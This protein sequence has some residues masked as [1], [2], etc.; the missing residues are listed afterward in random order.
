MLIDKNGII[1]IN[2][3]NSN[4]QNK[5][6]LIING[7]VIINSNSSLIIG[8][9]SINNDLLNI[10]GRIIIGTSN[11]DSSN[12]SLYINKGNVLITSNLNVNSNVVITSNLNVNGLIIGNGSNITNLKISELYLDNSNKKLNANYIKIDSNTGIN[13]DNSNQLFI[14]L[15]YSKFQITSNNEI[16]LT[17][18]A[19][20]SVWKSAN[21]NIN[22]PSEITKIYF[23]NNESFVGINND[24]PR[25]YLYVGPNGNL[26]RLATVND[27]TES[28]YSQIA[29]NDN[30][31][32]CNNT[33]IKLIPPV[34][35]SILLSSNNYDISGSI[36]YYTTGIN[37]V[38][39][40]NYES[41][42]IIT[43]LMNINKSGTVFINNTITPTN[44]EK[45]IV[46]GNLSV[47]NSNL[48]IPPIVKIGQKNTSN[49]ILQTYGSIIIGDSNADSSQYSL[50]VNSNVKFN[51]DLIIDGN[52]L[53]ASPVSFTNTVSIG[54]TNT[55]PI[56]EQTDI[57]YVLNVNG[58]IALNGIINTS[59]DV[60][61]KSNIKTCENSLD[62]ILNCRG[63]SFNYN[64][65]ENKNIGVIAQELEEVFPE[66]VN[67]NKEGYKN[68]N[69]IGIIGV[70]IEAIKDLN[71]KIENKN[72]L[73]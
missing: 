65:D 26:L 56:I 21:P 51:K 72:S 48:N 13:I 5:E 19:V 47:L 70:L 14:N 50:Y 10:T 68:V 41:N 31:N 6:K 61:L 42:G 2:P 3:L 45:L 30:I 43:P 54:T 64:D 17:N 28:Y 67:K 58:N 66:L 4:N 32:N 46:S 1:T 16:S 49:A 36:Y 27:I 39:C 11:E 22:I 55:A 69:Y 7:S 9:N 15:D 59:S 33:K 71:K 29:T 20:G 23:N 12:Y 52:I 40:F 73:I 38:H 57:N 8:S 25:S 24:D 44:N 34:Q 63:V 35:Q 37:P 53:G 60:R 62:K 18:T